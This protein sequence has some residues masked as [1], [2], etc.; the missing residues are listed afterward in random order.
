MSIPLDVVQL[1]HKKHSRKF[2]RRVFRARADLEAQRQRAAEFAARFGP[3]SKVIAML[4]NACT[5]G[6]VGQ[7]SLLLVKPPKVFSI[8]EDPVGAVSLVL[9]FAKNIQHDRVRSVKVDQ[10]K[11]EEYDLAAN[12]LLDIVA[13][14]AVRERR[15]RRRRLQMTGI[16]PQNAAV[17]R[18]IRSM[19]IVKH[20]NISHEIAKDG[21]IANIRL[22]D[23]RNKHYYVRQDPTKP[24]AKARTI[25]GFVNHF[26]SCLSDHKRAL[27]PESR[28]TLGAY[29]GEI[30]GNA[31]D[32]PGFVDWTIQGYLDNSLEMPLCEIAIIN[33][34][35]SIAETL[36][37][38]PKGHYT[39]KMIDPYIILHSG[40][41]FFR[42]EWRVADLL[43][44]IALQGHVSSKNSTKADSRGQGTGD[45]IDFFQR[46]HRECAGKG[47]MN[48]KMAIL[49]G[50]TY[51]LFDGTYL[52]RE[53]QDRGRVIAFNAQND[54]HSP[55]DP[56]Y[57][58]SLGSVHFPGTVISIRFPLS[59][60]STLTLGKNFDEQHS[61]N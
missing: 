25:E 49:S 37:E 9:Q 2:S 50:G 33:F 29:I 54:L 23:R 41:N 42:K 36:H 18:F 21:E 15:N 52:M 32:H 44:L 43:T 58:R 60:A 20:L 27:T 11:L 14:E 13:S 47:G 45:L 22:F 4:A 57:V 61:D 59:V 48:A 12:A 3:K 26:N 30:L 46:V 31:E 17:K 10:S 40:R 24:D 16:Y 34:G 1:L 28:A 35:K 6:P 55:P 19:G 39:R 56:K 8:I 7:S 51:V 38:L 53:S 5:I